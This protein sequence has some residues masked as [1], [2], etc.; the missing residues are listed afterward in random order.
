MVWKSC[1]KAS[2]RRVFSLAFYVIMAVRVR[3]WACVCLCSFQYNISFFFFILILL[4][5]YAYYTCTRSFEKRFH[6][7]NALKYWTFFISF[8]MYVFIVGFMSRNL[9]ILSCVRWVHSK[10]NRR[11]FFLSPQLSDR[12]II[13]AIDLSGFENPCIEYIDAM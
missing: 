3:V 1:A 2:N 9:E 10:W 13:H 6:R 11:A 12:H 8:N 7:K 4:F 5:L